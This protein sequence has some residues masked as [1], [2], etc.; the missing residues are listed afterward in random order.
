MTSVSPLSGLAAVPP[1]SPTRTTSNPAPLQADGATPSSIVSLSPADSLPSMQPRAANVMAWERKSND[2]VTSLMT[3][4]YAAQPLSGR[5]RGLGEALLKRFDTDA[6]GYSQAVLQSAAAAQPGA[7]TPAADPLALNT[8]HANAANQVALD[9]TTVSGIKVAITLGSQ[10]N[11]LA[12]E[13][14]SSGTLSDAERGALSQL[15]GA[16]QAAIDGIASVPPKMD[17]AGLAQFDSKLLSSVDLHTQV[18]AGG[19]QQQTLDFHAD[20]AQRSV[21][22]DG[23]QGSIKVSVDLRHLAG[24]G[25]A[26]QRGA[27]IDSYLKQFDQAGT[28]GHADAAMLAMFKD[29]F[30]QMNGALPKPGVAGA[31]P[32]A[33]AAV[34]SDT[35]HAI[36]TGLADFSASINEHARFP[37]PMRPDEGDGFAYDVAQ[38][39]AIGGHGTLDRSISQKQHAHLQASYHEPLSAGTKLALDSSNASQN[40][41]YTQ[42]SDDTDS[43]AEVGYTEGALTQASLKQSVNQST[44]VSTYVMGKLTDDTTTPTTV[45]LLRD[46]AG[47]LKDLAKKSTETPL[48]A[49][50]RKQQLDALHRSVLLQ[51]DAALLREAG[52]TRARE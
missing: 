52:N 35:D 37:N 23:P 30:Q 5:L 9:I 33:L 17:L 19:D 16:F 26:Q 41:T 42:I 46:L 3:V 22:T 12:V 29:A 48:D 10:P 6:G 38:A 32:H 14:S 31:Y 11:G 1:P 24:L 40:Y 51:Q 49:A 45:T 21:S 25:D 39:T 4:N 47:L 36:L 20:G 13:V 43:D 15:A 7:Q 50:L 34:L 8:L 18:Q 2:A 27:A 28:R 44:H